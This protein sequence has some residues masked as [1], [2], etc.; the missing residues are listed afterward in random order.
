[1]VDIGDL[2]A[3]D[4]VEVFRG[5]AAAHDQV[6]AAVLDLGHARQDRNGA[7]DILESAGQTADL[8]IVLGLHTQGLVADALEI[9]GFDGYAGALENGLI[10]AD[11]DIERFN[12]GDNEVRFDDRLVTDHGHLQ[13][14]GPFG[15]PFD[16]KRAV[17]IRDGAKCG[18]DDLDIGA[19][20]GFPGGGVEDEAGDA[21]D[22]LRRNG[23]CF[24]SQ[25]LYDHGRQYQ[26][27][28]QLFHFSSIP[29]HVFVFMFT[30]V[31]SGSR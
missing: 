29:C 15:D 11:A 28:K 7:H 25:R 26:E 24:R 2:D 20:Q 10:E 17:D 23:G 12:C 3:V 18:A 21:S 8:G 22:T 14:D 5:G 6:V 13:A 19:D 4:G 30:A 9:V 1:M 31:N 16:A 27:Y